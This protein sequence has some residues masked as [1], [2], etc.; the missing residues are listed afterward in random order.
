MTILA[1]AFKMKIMTDVFPYIPFLTE[2][3]VGVVSSL[4]VHLLTLGYH[5]Q[6]DVVVI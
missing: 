1:I 2:L 3:I 4:I 5:E 6:F